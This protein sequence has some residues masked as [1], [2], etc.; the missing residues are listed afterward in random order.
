MA[1]DS[2]P[3]PAP[4]RRVIGALIS[5]T[6]IGAAVGVGLY[7]VRMYYLYPRTDDAYVRANTVGIAP[8]VSGPIVNLPVVDN[9][10]VHEGDL[11]FEVDPQPY[12]H[13][14]E[15][16]EAQ[17][18]L[19]Q[20]EV[21]AYQEAIRAAR[22]E[23]SRRAA[24]AAYSQQY[25]ERITPLLDKH[26]VTANDVFNARSQVA[27]ADAAVRNAEAE[28]KRAENQL[29]KLGPINARLK[30]AEVAVAEARLNLD[31][32]TVRAPFDGYVTKLK[33]AVGQ[34]AN[35]GRQVLSLVDRRTWYVLANFREDF[36]PHIQPGMTADIFLLA[37]P[38][39]R[40]RGRVQGVGW[41]LYQE[42]G[43]T[44]E[45]LPA[46]EP[47]LN[48]VRLSQRFPVRI[49]LENRDPQRPFRTGQ[50]AVVKIEGLKD[51][52]AQQMRHLERQG[53]PY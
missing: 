29:G 5:V 49:V 41:A 13:T 47:T 23:Q 53:P 27:A 35:E 32:C 21:Q 40:F 34:Y 11:L 31:Y 26:Y 43:A 18:K 38:N 30:A 48:W 14:L 3:P 15:K 36:L 42:N 51:R 6:I 4:V 9:Q 46:V 17:L 33:I 2:S 1:A 10:P 24:D 44:V 16:A 7:V 50:T 28:A 12:Q 45:G 8:H 37:A 22:A 52:H 19:T 25:L 20:L 39:R